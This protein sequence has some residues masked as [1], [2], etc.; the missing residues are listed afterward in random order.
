MGHK[1][2]NYYFTILLCFSSGYGYS[3]STTSKNDLDQSGVLIELPQR[4]PNKIAEEYE[5]ATTPRRDYT[6][7]EIPAFL[8]LSTQDIT[9][10]ET[11]ALRSGRKDS[12]GMENIFPLRIQRNKQQEKKKFCMV[13]F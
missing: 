4:I 7:D 8:G 13:Y 9:N 11:I 12:T 3:L 2:K 1:F 5:V 10:L 6:Q